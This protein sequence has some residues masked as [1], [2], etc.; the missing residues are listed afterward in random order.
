MASIPSISVNALAVEWSLGVTA[1][2]NV[3][4]V[5]IFCFTL[6]NI[7]NK[8]EHSWGLSLNPGKLHNTRAWSR[9]LWKREGDGRGSVS[10]YPY[11]PPRSN[12]SSS[13]SFY[14]VRFH[15]QWSKNMSKD[16]YIYIILYIYFNTI[17]E[18]TSWNNIHLYFDHIEWS[19]SGWM[20]THR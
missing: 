16:I 19:S 8:V 15:A 18:K 3:T 20:K 1:H 14:F 10:V 17:E 2:R 6:V 12:D 9:N 11:T 4:A 13:F 5:V 7:W